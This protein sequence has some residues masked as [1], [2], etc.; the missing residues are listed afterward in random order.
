MKSGTAFLLAILLLLP[1]TSSADVTIQLY[2]NFFDYR[3]PTS[4]T[5]GSRRP[6]SYRNSNRP[7]YKMDIYLMEWDGACIDDA[8]GCDETDDDLIE[9]ATT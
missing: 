5:Y 8:S 1:S 2:A 6:S 3:T 4:D 9:M 7:V